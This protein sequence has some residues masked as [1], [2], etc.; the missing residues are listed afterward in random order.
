MNGNRRKT[1]AR[2]DGTDSRKDVIRFRVNA[3]EKAKIDLLM[4]NNGYRKVSIFMRDL[5]F[6][7]VICSHKE[8]VKVTD[9]QLRNQMNDITY[10]IRKLGEN[11]NQIVAR[12]NA[13]S[14]LFHPD[15][16]PYLNTEAVNR[17]METLR[18]ITESVRD[19]VSVAI[20]LVKRYTQEET[21]INP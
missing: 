19:E 16:R 12:Y 18:N 9:R 2:D 15:G 21:I 17:T 6:R 8:V 1:A 10:Q 4:K 5:V 3:Q 14:K 11:Y 13:Q 20:D 7:K